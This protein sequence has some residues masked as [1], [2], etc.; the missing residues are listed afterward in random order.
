MRTTRRA[1]ALVVAAAVAAGCGDSDSSTETNDQRSGETVAYAIGDGADGSERSARLARHVTGEEPDRFF[2]LGDVYETGTAAEFERN[3]EPLYGELADRTDPVIGN[4]EAP[5]I[6][7]GYYPYWEAQRGWTPAQAKHRSYVDPESGW[8]IIAYSS[9]TDAET[10]GK[11]VARQIA[12]HDGTCRVALAH[13]GRYA[14]ADDMHAD[15]P[16]QQH[17]WEALAGKTAINLVGHSHVYGRLRA[18][19]E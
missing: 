11:W 14:V 18:I 5:N 9:E 12:K 1:I 3:Y 19:D 4:H 6:H 13:R 2:Y 17:V 16:D 10:E 8:Q 15:N 7:R